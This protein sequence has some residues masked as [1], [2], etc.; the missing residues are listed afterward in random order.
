MLDDTKWNADFIGKAIAY[1][2]F[3]RADL[4]VPNCYWTGN[5]TDLL[6]I[7]RKGL[8]IIDVEI[9]ISRS[10]LKAD[11]RKDKW[12]VK[13]PWSRRSGQ[14]TRLEWPAKVW[15]HYYVMPAEIWDPKLYD[16]IP[17]ASGIVT[18]KHQRSK[19]TPIS[20]VLVRRAKPNREAKPISP[21]DAIDLARL[22]TLRMWAALTK[23]KQ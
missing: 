15:K 14:P 18:L 21:H 4:V 11:L 3:K 6:V 16:D 22:A 7:E 20:A 13:R 9:K 12:W 10:D 5:E 2:I 19:T 23:E 8:R 1:Q 17:Q